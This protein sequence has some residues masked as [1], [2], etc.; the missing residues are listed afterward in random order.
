MKQSG[1][2]FDATIANKSLASFLGFL[3]IW[4]RP[5]VAMSRPRDVLCIL[6]NIEPMR[7]LL[8]DL[9]SKSPQWALF[10]LDLLGLGDI[11]D[12]DAS[13]VRPKSRDEFTQSPEHWTD[14]QSQPKQKAQKIR[15]APSLYT[16]TGRDGF[17][18]LKRKYLIELRDL[19]EKCSANVKAILNAEKQWGEERAARMEDEMAN[20]MMRLELMLLEDEDGG[21]EI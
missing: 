10:L 7:E 2:S 11:C 3:R 15:L 16:T 4:N 14:V 18:D 19:R 9:Y 8:D 17:S 6:L 20:V 13:P 5:N 21:R 12:L 1:F